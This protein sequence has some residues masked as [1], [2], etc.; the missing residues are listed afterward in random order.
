MY[1]YGIVLWEVYTRSVSLVPFL[2]FLM[3]HDMCSQRVHPT[4]TDSQIIARVAND[5]LRPPVSFLC[6]W[7]DLMQHCWAE[8]PYNRPNFAAI[9]SSLHRIYNGEE[10]GRR[11]GTVTAHNLS[12]H[13]EILQNRVRNYHK[14]EGDDSSCESREIG[15]SF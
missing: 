4:L 13:N 2:L 5:G 1:S 14:E 9:V 6:P 10:D 15:A 7:G 11:V 8:R 3:L 12:R